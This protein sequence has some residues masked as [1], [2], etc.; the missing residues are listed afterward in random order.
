MRK[1]VVWILSFCLLTTLTL[2]ACSPTA[3][4]TS[5]DASSMTDSADLVTTDSGLKYTDVTV[6]DGASPEQGDEVVVHYTGRLTNGTV[7]DSSYD[8]G[9]PFRFTLGGGQVIQGW[10]EG[11]ASMQVG[12]KRILVIPPELGYGSRGAGGVIPPNATLEFEVELLDIR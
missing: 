6:G 5:G 12:G 9:E 1:A 11:V 7:F 4:N 8:R 2:S 3:T 10:D